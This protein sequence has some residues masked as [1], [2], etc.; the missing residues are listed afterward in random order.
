MHGQVRPRADGEILPE[1]IIE[2]TTRAS[3]GS[4]PDFGA[5]YENSPLAT[6]NQKQLQVRAAVACF[7]TI[8]SRRNLDYV[9]RI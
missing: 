4:R 5:L 7:P 8:F 3:N 6:S 2:V 1:Y 9:K